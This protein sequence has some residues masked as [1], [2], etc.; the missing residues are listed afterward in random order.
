MKKF[1]FYL[2]LFII[3]FLQ[4]KNV[5]AQIDNVYKLEKTS[6]TILKY[7]FEYKIIKGEN[8]IKPVGYIDDFILYKYRDKDRNIKFYKFNEDNN[9][10]K[11]V[12][13][14]L[15]L[16]SKFLYQFSTK[17]SLIFFKKIFFSEI[18]DYGYS[19]LIVLY[20]NK[21]H[22]IDSIYNADKK[23][24]SSFSTNGKFLIVNT[25]NTL[26]DYYNSDQDDRIYVYLLDSLKKGK[27][28]KDDI[29]CKYCGDGYLVGDDFYFTKS[30]ERDDFSGG[31]KWKD[32]YVSPWSQLKDSVKIASYT[33][34]L[35]ISPDGK[36]ILGTR[37]FDLP[38]SPCAI[39][40]VVNKK[41]QLLLGRDYSKADAFFSY[42]E[43][44]FAFNFSD[45][46][47]YIDFPEEYPFD[48][49]KKDNTEIPGWGDIEFYSQFKHAPFEK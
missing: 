42:K 25:L 4:F 9:S 41:Y 7:N 23:I 27:V 1:K 36:Y 32:I 17:D 5:V 19:Q 29:F 31:F 45:R 11:Q 14:D 38:N 34:I 40:D 22:V 3:F 13:L 49:L 44:K 39:I 48:A 46:I 28:I 30:N 47:V 35:A 20:N 26:S 37:Q 43:K 21:M 15:N 6:E 18:D 2:L 10:F 16:N 8:S 24:H 33:N 12:F